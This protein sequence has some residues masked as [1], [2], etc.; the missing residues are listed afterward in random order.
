MPARSD[1]SLSSGQIVSVT[2]EKPAAGGRMIAR[3]DG[4]VALVAG[5][6]PGELVRA[7]VERVTR[8]VVFME[9]IA[10]DQPSQDRRDAGGDSLCGGCLFKHIA[11]PRQL[12]IKSQ[13]IADAFARIAHLSLPEPV[14]VAASPEEGYRMRARLHVRESRI[15]FFREGTHDLCDPRPTRQ[16]L[17]ITCDVIDRLAAAIGSLSIR[18]VRE[19]EIAENIDASDRAVALNTSAA[20]DPRALARLAAIDGVTGLASQSG[21]FGTPSVVDRLTIE[22]APIALRRHAASFFQGNRHLLRRFAEHVT[23]QIP[24]DCELLD[25]YAGVG[26]F[27]VA[28]ASVQGARTTAVEGDR[29]A[30]T[31]LAAN[32]SMSAGA[33]TTVCEPVEEFVG[34]RNASALRAGSTSPFVI[35]TD[36]PRTGMSAAALDGLIR[37]HADRIVYVS[38]DV[39]TLARDARKIVDAGYALSRG[40]AFDLFPNTPHVETILVF[41][42]G[43]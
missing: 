19:I 30:A 17:P 1:M 14:E 4:Q 21:S 23:R 12:E 34:S 37:L 35:V 24:S 31:D 15:G 42:R 25:L 43:R 3:I 33:V 28:A 18:A 32:A 10:V 11:Y 40:D 2:I 29:L 5:A 8:G 38:C 20:V 16:L 22:D 7:R 39:A 13:V 27:S 6:I 41:D 26:L 9:T 36:P